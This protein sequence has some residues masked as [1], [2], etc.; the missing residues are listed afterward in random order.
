MP[1][2]AAGFHA[3]D[4]AFPNFGGE[5]RAEPLPPEPDSFVANID[6]ALM[7]QV[8]D[9]PK[10]KREPDIEHHRE[11]DDLG[12]GLEVAEGGSFAHLATLRNESVRPSVYD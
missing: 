12:A 8:L 1:P 4:P 11:A 9:V 2:P 6:A 7:E 5:H 3:V 10:R